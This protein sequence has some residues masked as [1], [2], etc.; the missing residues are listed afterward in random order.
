[1]YDEKFEITKSTYY[2]LHR[3]YIIDKGIVL[4]NLWINIDMIYRTRKL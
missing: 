1:M 2:M 3:F 4:C